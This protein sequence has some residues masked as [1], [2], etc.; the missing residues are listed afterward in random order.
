MR[1][2]V[3]LSLALAALA[4]AAGCGGG[5]TTVIERTVVTTA[6]TTTP[7]PPTTTT[8]PTTSAQPASERCPDIPDVGPTGADPADAVNVQVTY[9]DCTTAVRLARRFYSVW[10]PSGKAPGDRVTVLGFRCGELADSGGFAAR[11]DCNHSASS[12]TFDV[13]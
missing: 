5:T 8:A 4:V 10:I 12:V 7:T 6:P 11:V 9:T 1:S 13:Q 3:S 2:I